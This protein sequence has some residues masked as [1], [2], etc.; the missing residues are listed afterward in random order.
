LVPYFLAEGVHLVRDLTAARDALI[1]RYP[2]IEFVLTRPL[3]PH[4][5][6]NQLVLERVREVEACGPPALAPAAEMARRY[7]PMGEH[8]QAASGGDGGIDGDRAS[9]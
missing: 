6:L 1:A 4:P 7:A 9:S 2:G 3:G 8:G 5:L